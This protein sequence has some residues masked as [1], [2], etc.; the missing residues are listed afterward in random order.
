M[1]IEGKL[2]PDLFNDFAPGDNVEVELPAV[3]K[4][5]LK[6]GDEVLVKGYVKIVNGHYELKMQLANYVFLNVSEIVSILPPEPPRSI[7]WDSLKI[8]PDAVGTISCEGF[9]LNKL[10]EIVKEL[11]EGKCD[12]C[13]K[14][15]AVT[16]GPPMTTER[17]IC[18]TCIS[19]FEAE[20]HD[21]V[22]I[23]CAKCESEDVRKLNREEEAK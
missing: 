18:K 16:Q 20:D 17:F 3:K 9:A 11:K 14:K 4:E 10:I 19:V 15:T 7:D 5:E 2:I 6:D 1:K 22:T 8:K 23:A 21:A 12:I 13:K